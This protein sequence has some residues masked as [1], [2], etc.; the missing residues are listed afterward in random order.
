MEF[1][2]RLQCGWAW[3][4]SCDVKEADTGNHLL[5]DSVYTKGFPDGSAVKNLPAM[6]ETQETWVWSLGR[7]DPLEEE[8]VTHCSILAWKIPWTEEPGRLQFKGLQRVKHN[9]ANKQASCEAEWCGC[10]QSLVKHRC[11]DLWFGFFFFPP[12]NF[13]FWVYI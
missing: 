3:K 7:E 8:V 11:L 10:L 5:D 1:G 12:N 4:T 6:P 2:Y 9:W 13:A